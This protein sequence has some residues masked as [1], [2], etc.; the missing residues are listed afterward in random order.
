MTAATTERKC[1]RNCHHERS[2]AIQNPSV[3]AV[4]IASSQG[5]LAMTVVEAA[6]PDTL[7]SRTRCN[8]P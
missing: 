8:A 2:E 1:A 4:W 3:D 5:L 6:V 7:V